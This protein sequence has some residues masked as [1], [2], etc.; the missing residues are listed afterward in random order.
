MIVFRWG[1]ILRF[2]L[3][4]AVLAV[5]CSGGLGQTLVPG[6]MARVATVDERFQSFNVEMVEVTGGRFWAPYKKA[7]A[8]A[9]AP[10]DSALAT[11]GID[12]SAFRQRA[13]IDLSNARL[14]KLAAALG[15][16]YVRVSGTWANST[17]FHDSDSA[18]P[19]KPPAGFGGV[20]TRAEWKSVVDF[21]RAVNAKI[22]TS[23]AIS[24]GV[25]DAQGVW[26]PVEAKKII[27][28]TKAVG[29]SIAAAEMFNE[30]SFASMGGAPKGYDAL[31]YGRDFRVFRAFVKEA[32]PG[33][34][35]L[36]PGSVGEGTQLAGSMAMIRSED[37]LKASGPGV[38]AFSY[39]YYGGVSKRCNGTATTEAALSEAWLAGTEHNEEY[40]QAL[41]DRFEPGK[42]IWLT[43]TGETACGGNPWASTFLD[44]FRYL[45]Q[46]GRLAKKGVRVVA[47]NTLAASDYGLIDEDT[48]IP[49]PNYWSALLWRNLMGTTVL[50][51]GTGRDGIHLYA[52]CLRGKPGGVAVLALNTDRTGSHELEV[53]DQYERYTLASKELTSGSVELNGRE[54]KLGAGDQMPGIEGKRGAAGRV[55]LAPATVTF[56]AFP[57]AKNA[58]CQ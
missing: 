11:P 13:P 17:Y 39:H 38:D 21:S 55:S 31:G 56:L 1:E 53:A 5:T 52:H 4:P 36:G 50:D 45:D 26:T 3:V 12:P 7:G 42:P 27:S 28:Y 51:A 37:M 35:I 30:P 54:L 9:E 20:L 2:W 8:P 57:N 6:K 29:G 32:A 40:Y 47:H 15:P 19:A 48:L 49:R 23:F 34:T 18:A 16:A 44:S 24:D 43:E 41:R 22:V 46:L 25:R 33:M 14:R 58:A 10:P